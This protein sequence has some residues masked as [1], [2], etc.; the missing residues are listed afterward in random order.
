MDYSG[1]N[2]TDWAGHHIDIAHWGLGLD[3]TG[4]L[5][6]EGRGRTNNDGYYNVPAEYDFTCTYSN[7]VTM[8]VANE[9]KL[10]HGMATVWYGER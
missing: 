8:R 5:S 10:R 7:G 4:P 3:N 1:V 9:S 2:L 6:V